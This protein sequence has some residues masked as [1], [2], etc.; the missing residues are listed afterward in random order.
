MG[1]F[2]FFATLFPPLGDPLYFAIMNRHLH[3]ILLLLRRLGVAAGVKLLVEK[4]DDAHVVLD[5]E[6]VEERL[7][8]LKGKQPETL[9]VHLKCAYL[10][11]QS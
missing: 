1:H 2:Q 10:I 3:K 4:V 6:V 5:A 7:A 9:K 8:D 11:E